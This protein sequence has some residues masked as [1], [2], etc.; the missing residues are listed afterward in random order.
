MKV[1]L[2]G[3]RLFGWAFPMFAGLAAVTTARAGETS[4]LGREIPSSSEWKLEASGGSESV[5]ADSLVIHTS[6]PTENRAYFWSGDLGDGKGF[7]VDVELFLRSG[8]SR[9]YLKAIGPDGPVQYNL[10]LYANGLLGAYAAEGYRTAK[11]P[12]GR[13]ESLHV[14]LLGGWGADMV[15]SANGDPK[16]LLAFAPMPAKGKSRPGLSLGDDSNSYAAE[17]V[18]RRVVIRR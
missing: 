16:E 15:V 3:A 13:I 1:P 18:V 11:V 12:G 5:D 4:Y 10:N 9:L 8:I 17:L 6:V 7:Q 2:V 14:K